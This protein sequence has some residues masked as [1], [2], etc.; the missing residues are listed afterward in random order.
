MATPPLILAETFTEYFQENAF[1]SVDALRTPWCFKHHVDD[2][3][4]I[5]MAGKKD[6]FLQHVN[7]LLP[8]WVSFTAEKNSDQPPLPLE[9]WLVMVGEIKRDCSA[10]YIRE[11]GNSRIHRFHAHVPSVT[12]SNMRQTD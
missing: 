2:T 10:S 1:S 12:A 7:S 3:F 8:E 6:P 11:T 4:A 9:H 5:M